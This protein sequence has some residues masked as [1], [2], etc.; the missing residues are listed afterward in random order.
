MVTLN[1]VAAQA[2][3]SARAVSHAVNGTGRLAPETRKRILDIVRR[4]GYRKNHAATALRSGKSRLIGVAMPSPHLPFYATMMTSIQTRLYKAGYT[5]VFGLWGEGYHMKEIFASLFS[6]KIDGIITWFLPEQPE[7]LDIPVV[8]YSNR[9][10][11][12]LPDTVMIDTENTAIRAVEFLKTRHFRKVG[13]IANLKDPRSV[14]LKEQCGNCGIEIRPEWMF[15]CVDADAD[16]E[17]RIAEVFLNLKEKPEL[18]VFTDDKVCVDLACALKRHGVLPE[19]L[20][21]RNSYLLPLIGK[22]MAA[23]DI[24]EETIA[25]ALVDLLLSRLADP[26]IPARCRKIEADLIDIS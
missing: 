24:H 26:S 3:V 9:R 1:D 4:L 21:F 12:D 6:M 13:I 11:S 8:H 19:L 7:K 18:L 25:A 20:C 22:K 14:A 10:K 5:A 2:G 17:E 15:Q 16:R 23:F